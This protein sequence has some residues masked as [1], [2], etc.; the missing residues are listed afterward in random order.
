MAPGWRASVDPILV[1]VDAGARGDGGGDRLDRS[2]LHIGQH[3]RGLANPE[4]LC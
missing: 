1:R 4:L 3:K 2:L